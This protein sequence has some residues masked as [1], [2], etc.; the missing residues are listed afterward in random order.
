MSWFCI[1]KLNKYDDLIYNFKKIK[2]H[3]HLN[4]KKNKI[5]HYKWD[6]TLILNNFIRKGLK[7]KFIK[8][9]IKFFIIIK[10]YKIINKWNC[11]F[12]FFNFIHI[13]EENFVTPVFFLKI[14]KNSSKKL[15]SK[16]NK[17]KKLVYSISIIFCKNYLRKYLTRKISILFLNIFNYYFLY[18]SFIYCFEIFIF[19]KYIINKIIYN[20]NKKA[21]NLYY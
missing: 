12:N 8:L 15:K 11:F 14:I 16:K 21:M 1:K 9:I 2:R 3:L 7:L 18:I 17:K 5:F 10:L 13:L 4:K 6:Y 19:K 20:V